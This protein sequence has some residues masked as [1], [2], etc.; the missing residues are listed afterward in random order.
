MGLNSK[1][2]ISCCCRVNAH[3]RTARVGR[4]SGADETWTVLC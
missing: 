4:G 3:M 1:N 2:D